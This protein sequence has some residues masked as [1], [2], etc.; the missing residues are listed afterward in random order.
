MTVIL[1]DTKALM[2]TCSRDHLFQQQ[3]PENYDSWVEHRFS[4]R[5]TKR[6]HHVPAE[7]A[8]SVPMRVCLGWGTTD[9][10]V[11]DTAFL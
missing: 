9:S 10:I 8:A 4:L 3:Q 6:C 2:E 11:W 5:Y 1:K 7:G